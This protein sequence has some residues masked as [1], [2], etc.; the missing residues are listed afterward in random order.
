MS[1]F[2]FP[3]IIKDWRLLKSTQNGPLKNIRDGI[4]RPQGGCKTKRKVYTDLVDTQYKG[5]TALW[6]YKPKP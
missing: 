2:G 4:S 1:R 6:V 5:I 3:Q